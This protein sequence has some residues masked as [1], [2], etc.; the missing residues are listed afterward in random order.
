M[1]MMILET[2]RR[3]LQLRPFEIRIT[4]AVA[5]MATLAQM[6]NVFP[7]QTLFTWEEA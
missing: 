4:L 7:L 5:L 3:A 6:T 2:R 1:I